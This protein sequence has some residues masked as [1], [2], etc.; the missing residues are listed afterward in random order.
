MDT[1]RSISSPGFLEASG[2]REEEIMPCRFW[3][4]ALV[5]RQ[6]EIRV[7]LRSWSL[8][9]HLA[10]RKTQQEQ[11]RALLSPPW[12]LDEK[13]S[14]CPVGSLQEPGGQFTQLF[15][16]KDPGEPLLD[17]EDLFWA[18]IL[19]EKVGDMS[20]MECES[21]ARSITRLI[22]ANEC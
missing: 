5:L 14:S 12:I 13:K 6:R 4:L 10:S 9:F 11:V 3:S 21:R 1:P 15:W 19:V 17:A 8:W 18:L 7:S 22:N 2:L 16:L 20:S